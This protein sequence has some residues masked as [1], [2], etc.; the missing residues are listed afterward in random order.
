VL[1]GTL[2]AAP[3]AAADRLLD[4]MFADHALVQRDR[5]IMVWGK[6]APGESV[7]ITFGKAQASARAGADG[8]WRAALPAMKAGGPYVLSAR[9]GAAALQIADVL[10]GDVFLCSG[11]SNMEW[12]VGAAVDGKAEVAASADPGIRLLTVPQLASATPVPSLAAPAPWKRAGPDST[13]DFSAVCFFMAQDL[14]KKRPDVPIGLIDNSWGGSAISAW[15]SPETYRASGGDRAIADLLELYRR[16]PAAAN[17]AWGIQWQAWWAARGRHPAETRPWEPDFQPGSNWH[18]VPSLTNWESW[19]IADLAEFNGLLWY[20]AKV[21]LTQA[22]AAQPAVLKLGPVDE[23]DTT[24]VNGRPIGYTSGAG[25]PRRYALPAGS[26]HAG[27]NVIVVSALDTYANGGIYGPPEDRALELGDGSSIKLD[28][29]DWL[30]RAVTEFRDQPSRAPWD[31]IAGV[32]TID[33]GMVLPIGA[34]GVKGATWYQGESNTGDGKRY[35]ALLRGLIGQWRSRW[36]AGLAVG[37]VQLPGYGA[38]PTAPVE[39]GWSD[40]REGQRRAV[41]GDAHS[42]LVVTIDVGDAANLH[43]PAKRPVGERLARAIEHI[44]YGAPAS[45]SGPMPVDAGRTGQGIV[46]RFRDVDGSLADA[47]G[48]SAFELCGAAT[49]SCRS[50]PARISGKTVILPADPA[51][52]RIRYC[53]G[54]APRCSLRDADLPSTPFELELH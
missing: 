12:P 47:S 17:V 29:L 34:W 6:A 3:A 27:D 39:S 28:S 53:W 13:G 1:A 52:T 16:D 30:Y 22:Q 9:A 51:A 54:D 44:A 36:G 8:S 46:I 42:A 25:T 2:L 45:A 24:W 32:S 21:Q 7:A 5:P 31:A 49:G 10:V 14:R 38:I 4:P 11:Q 37:V 48:G 23:V 41:E 40:V 18:K 43:P 19:G 26:L 20:R 15:L 35:E 33:N 50:V